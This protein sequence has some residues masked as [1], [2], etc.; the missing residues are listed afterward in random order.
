MTKGLSTYPKNSARRAS[1]LGEYDRRQR[2]GGWLYGSDGAEAHAPLTDDVGVPATS[3]EL[4]LA[5]HQQF[6]GLGQLVVRDLGG[7]RR[8]PPGDPTDLSKAAPPEQISVAVGHEAFEVGGRDLLLAQELRGPLRLSLG[9]QSG[10][11]LEA[12]WPGGVGLSH[13]VEPGPP[14]PATR[15]SEKVSAGWCVPSAAEFCLFGPAGRL[16]WQGDF[17]PND[18]ARDCTNFCHVR[19][20]HLGVAQAI[21]ERT[22]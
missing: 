12:Q 13:P 2:R 18:E 20:R 6:V 11:G 17:H 7:G 16:G 19:R 5:E 8:L 1:E 14:G 10:Q 9:L 21:A 15:W 3:H 22:T 4:K